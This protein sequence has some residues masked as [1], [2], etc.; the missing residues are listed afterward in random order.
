MS[1]DNNEEFAQELRRESELKNQRAT[2]NRADYEVPYNRE[3]GRIGQ[4]ICTQ[5]VIIGLAILIGIGLLAFG[6]LFALL[7]SIREDQ[8]NRL[9]TDNCSVCPAG[10]QGPIGPAGGAGP[11]GATGPMGNDGIQGPVGPEGPA[12]PEGPPGTCAGNPMDPCP[13]GPQ[14]PPGPQGPQGLQGIQGLQGPQ[15]IQGEI[16]PQGFNGTEGPEGPQGPVGPEGPQGPNGTCDCTGD[17]TFGNVVIEGDIE[18]E[19]N[20][21]CLAPLDNSCFGLAVC[22]DFTLCDLVSNTMQML[23]GA[24]VGDISDGID[25][26][27]TNDVIFGENGIY[28]VGSIRMNGKNV[29]IDSLSSINM[30]AS[31]NMLL[32]SG[33]GGATITTQGQGRFFSIDD[34]VI[35][36]VTGNITMTSTTNGIT[37]VTPS[38]IQMGSGDAIWSTGEF[39]LQKNPAS[40]WIEAT[41]AD[42]Q[43][44]STGL[45]TS[46]ADSINLHEDV[47]IRNN[48]SI[49]ADASVNEYL[50]VGPKLEICSN[51]IRGTND[52]LIIGSDDDATLTIFGTISGGDNMTCVRID[53]CMDISGVIENSAGDVIV[54]DDMQVTGNL[55][56]GLDG[57]VNGTFMAGGLTTLKNGLV[58]Q[59]IRALDMDTLDIT[60]NTEITGNLTVT[61]NVAINGNG[62]IDG[63]LVVTGD[64]DC[65]GG[66]CASDMRLKHSV[67]DV[68][69]SESLERIAKMGVID[70][71][72]KEDFAKSRGFSETERFRGFSAQKMKKIVPQ[73]VNKIAVKIGD[74]VKEI[75][76]LKKQEIVSDLVGAVQ[77]LLKESQRQA[78]QI[79][80]L[81]SKLDRYHEGDGTTI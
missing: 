81:R 26:G 25:S 63:N 71:S 37:I 10:P 8:I 4:Q 22:P 34:M 12:G 23:N 56:V 43:I 50:V 35:Q 46:F 77:A 30:D 58:V 33:S 51:Q 40:K 80:Y 52:D 15:G 2:A 73:A 29:R 62:Q 18:F 79:A 16:G 72:F 13:A 9:I 11:P 74:E 60:S 17:N 42:S 44:C 24:T 61:Q 67:E 28:N 20:V 45:P 7:P 68:P 31:T 65:S 48:R 70:F 36:T 1:Y 53:D 19:G 39:T 64:V 27:A 49:M 54:D 14:G 78:R 38:F 66:T 21:T 5:N 41:Q 32:A 75:L 76:T 69:N 57:N 3:G 6:L 55:D 47:I 59:S